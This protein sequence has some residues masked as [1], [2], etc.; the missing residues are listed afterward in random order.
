M[1]SLSTIQRINFQDITDKF[2]NNVNGEKVSF[3]YKI[4]EKKFDSKEKRNN[5]VWSIRFHQKETQS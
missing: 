2:N 3:S 5:E 4:C 1:E